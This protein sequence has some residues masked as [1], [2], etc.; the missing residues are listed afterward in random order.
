[1][2]V[3]RWQTDKNMLIIVETNKKWMSR[4]QKLII[5]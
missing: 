2:A 1:L 4:A 3:T 5:D